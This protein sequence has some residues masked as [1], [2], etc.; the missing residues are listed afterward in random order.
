MEPVILQPT[1]LVVLF[2][3]IAAVRISMDTGP[4]EI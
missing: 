3:V 2:C 1:Y 4:Y